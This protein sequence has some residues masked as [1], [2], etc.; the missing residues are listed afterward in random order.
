MREMYDNGVTQTV[1]LAAGMGTRL[2]SAEAGV[3]KPLMSIGG[4]PLVAY[5]L[6]QAEAA[7]CR[8][9]V[10]VIGYEGARVRKAVE[11]IGSSMAI[12]FV[13]NPDPTAPNGH[14]LLAARPVAAPRFFL[15]M[16]DH[17]FAAPI[18]TRLAAE[19][20]S[21][22]EAARLLVDRAPVNLDLSDATKVRLDGSRITAIGKAVEPW[23][24]ID[25]GIFLLTRAVFES[26]DGIGSSEPLTVSSVMRQQ[27]K[28]RSFSAVD[29]GGVPW[30]DVDTP[31]DRHD[32]EQR[33]AGWG[34]IAAVGAA[35]PGA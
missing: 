30:V 11:T 21:R 29:I 8:E 15:Q 28:E 25:T 1:I 7:G 10:I 5:A 23:D 3:P 33:L 18:L 24:A 27:V 35:A 16:V 26:A 19:P 12:R 31:A 4:V 6:G 22:G 32:A 2:G 13:E 34:R 14:S 9:A 17:L 20:F